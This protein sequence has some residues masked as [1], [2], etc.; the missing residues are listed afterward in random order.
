[1]AQADLLNGTYATECRK[2]GRVFVVFGQ[3]FEDELLVV[4]SFTGE[5][6]LSPI[7]CF[8]SA[9]AGHDTP[10]SELKKIQGVFIELAGQFFEEIFADD[11]WD[12]WEPHWQEVDYQKKAYWYKLSRENV[13]LTLEADRLLLAAGFDPDDTE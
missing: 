7:T 8:L 11:M 12:E 13:A 1:M 9:D 3:T 4:V 6:S 2:S 10:T 5:K